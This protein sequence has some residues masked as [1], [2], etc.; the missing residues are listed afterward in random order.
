V[1]LYELSFEDTGLP[2]WMVARNFEQLK[3]KLAGIIV[4]VMA[5]KFLEQFMAWQQPAATLQFGLALTAVAAVLIALSLFGDKLS[6][7]KL[8]ATTEKGEIG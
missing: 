1:S 6:P 5:V 8:S 7:S 2:D 4:L 3:S